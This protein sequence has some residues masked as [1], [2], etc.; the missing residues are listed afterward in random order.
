MLLDGMSS[1]A[2][3]SPHHLIKIHPSFS[4]TLAGM[5]QSSRELVDSLRAAVD[6]ALHAP[7][8][9]GEERRHVVE[10]D[11]PLWTGNFGGR[12]WRWRARVGGE[13]RNREVGFMAYAADDRHGARANGARDRLIVE[14]PQVFNASATTADDEHVAFAPG[15][16]LRN[17]ARDFC[18]GAVALH[19]GGI[20]DDAR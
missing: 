1:S 19:H 5:L 2:A 15:C 4:Q 7:H 8:E 18:S 3:K 16:R 6:F 20:H 17:G 13:I 10:Q 12:R 14:C 9:H 11:L